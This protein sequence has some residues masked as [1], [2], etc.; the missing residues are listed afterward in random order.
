LCWIVQVR[1]NASCKHVCIVGWLAQLLLQHFG[2]A[3]ICEGWQ[4]A[5]VEDEGL[6]QL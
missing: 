6:A 2:Q 4:V 1:V 5:K 3:R